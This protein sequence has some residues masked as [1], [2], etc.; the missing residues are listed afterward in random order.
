MCGSCPSRFS[1]TFDK[2]KYAFKNNPFVPSGGGVVITLRLLDISEIML[3]ERNS[4]ADNY[5]LGVLRKEMDVVNMEKSCPCIDLGKIAF[6]RTDHPHTTISC[7]LI[8]K[9]E[10]INNE[11]F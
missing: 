5:L 1:C 3:N 11:L 2:D 4:F 7:L 9:K 8:F 10:F 6:I